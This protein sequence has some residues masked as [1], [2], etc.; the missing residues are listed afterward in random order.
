MPADDVLIEESG[1]QPGLSGIYTTSTAYLSPI[2]D[3]YVG[4]HY[5]GVYPFLE[6]PVGH[7]AIYSFAATVS[8]FIMKARYN[9]FTA[10]DV[11]Y[12]SY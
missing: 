11:I 1:H 4:F 2:V 5:I 12:D 8:A 9:L 7:L 3:I 6:I 10:L